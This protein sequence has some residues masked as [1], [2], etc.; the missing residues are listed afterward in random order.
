MSATATATT[1]NTF[2]FLECLKSNAITLAVA[3]Y[4]I[5]IAYYMTKNPEKLFTKLYLY[6]TIA[7]VPLFIGIIFALKNSGSDLTTITR[8]D[9]IKY[10]VGFL[11]FLLVVY[12]LNNINLSSK[13]V[14]LATGFI[15]LI[16]VLMIIV[17][18]AIIYKIGYIPS[19]LA[20]WRC[21]K[22]DPYKPKTLS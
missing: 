16:V 14:F 7:V 22:S 8:S 5:V 17:A 13:M 20:C 9:Y 10:G 12:F 4:M 18:L 15:Q 6:V 19:F 11:A 2:N 1:T 21:A 3:I